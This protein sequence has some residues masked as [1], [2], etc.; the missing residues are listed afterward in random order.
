MVCI[1]F[2]LGPPNH[3]QK[4]PCLLVFEG[5]YL[6]FMTIT[7]PPSKTSKCD[8]I[9]SFSMA[10][11]YFSSSPPNHPRKRAHLLV[12][13]GGYFDNPFRREEGCLHLPATSI[14]LFGVMRGCLHPLA[15]SISLFGVTR[16]CLHLPTTS[17]TS[18]RVV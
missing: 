2:S 1:C 6:F 8:H 4:Q 3:L 16:R 5:V 17:I 7:Q 14:S 10:I 18:F 15:T 11:T 12:F 9:Y 13:D